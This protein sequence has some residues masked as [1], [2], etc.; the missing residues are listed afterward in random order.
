MRP[1]AVIHEVLK[2]RF[3]GVNRRFMTGEL[4][5]DVHEY[6]D[7]SLAVFHGPRRLQAVVLAKPEENEEVDFSD[8]FIA[9]APNSVWKS[10]GEAGSS[11]SP[12]TG[13]AHGA[14]VA[15]QRCPLLRMAETLSA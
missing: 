13:D 1:T 4:G 2:M 8:A 11:P 6:L 5:C 12:D 15:R 10:E 3:F 14:Q 9:L 7:D